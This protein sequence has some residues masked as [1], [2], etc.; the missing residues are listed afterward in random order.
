M[1]FFLLSTQPV[2][3]K[4]FW[5]K[6]RD[7]F[8]M[9]AG[10][11]RVPAQFREWWEEGSEKGN[12]S[13]WFDDLVIG[14]KLGDAS[15]NPA[16]AAW[17]KNESFPGIGATRKA[18]PYAVKNHFFEHVS[19][20]E[21]VQKMNTLVTTLQK[22]GE[23]GEGPKVIGWAIN[24]SKSKGENPS[25][26]LRIVFENLHHRSDLIASGD[27]INTQSAL[28]QLSNERQKEAL[29]KVLRTLARHP[30]PNRSNVFISVTKDPLSDGG[31]RIDSHFIDIESPLSD[32]HTKQAYFDPKE[33]TGEG[34]TENFWSLQRS[35]L[36]YFPNLELNGAGLAV[37]P[38]EVFPD[39]VGNHLW[40]HP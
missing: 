5:L 38:E 24:V 23:S 12:V 10:F 6:C 13:Q 28:S 35:L 14:D 40:K 11:K 3:A 31:V 2:F 8:E 39:L 27:L 37:L 18:P 20:N 21:V 4:S 29:V 36:E 22:L 34:I 15:V 25:A 32:R 26:M 30:D 1:F 16:R 7:G 17:P 19:E 9:L 33:P